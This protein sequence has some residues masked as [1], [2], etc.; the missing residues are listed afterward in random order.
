MDS[1]PSSLF[2]SN[3]VRGGVYS[4]FVG[5]RGLGHTKMPSIRSGNLIRRFSF[6]CQSSIT[7]S[8]A[9]G[10]T[11]AMRSISLLVR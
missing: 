5:Q 11:R 9:S 2:T 1:T 7:F 4:A 10:A 6:T 8:V 3:S